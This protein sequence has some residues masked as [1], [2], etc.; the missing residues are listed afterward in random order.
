MTTSKDMAEE[1][2]HEEFLQQHKTPEQLLKFYNEQY[3]KTGQPLFLLAAFCCH[4]AIN[5]VGNDDV[6]VPQ[7]ITS[8]LKKGF[9]EYLD[10]L[11]GE[12]KSISL[13]Q[14]LGI[15]NEIKAKA[16]IPATLEERI[17][18]VH[19]MRWLFGLNLTNSVHATYVKYKHLFGDKGVTQSESVFKQHYERCHSKGFPAWVKERDPRQLTE[20]HRQQFLSTMS[21]ELAGRVKRMMKPNTL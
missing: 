20:Q 11:A 7:W 17:E 15:T 18:H 5:E 3:H 9:M 10:T 21:P 2:M 14:A 13:E 16:V 6:P 8:P 4:V 12:D 1:L 19:I